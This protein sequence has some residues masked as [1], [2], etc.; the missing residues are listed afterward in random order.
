M[1][2]LE[3][4]PSR[5]VLQDESCVMS[6]AHAN[7]GW[8]VL[9]PILLGMSIP[10][11]L[12]ALLAPKLLPNGPLVFGVYLVATFVISSVIFV[13]SVF[14]P[15]NIIEATFDSRKRA[16]AFVRMGTFGTTFFSVPFSAI[17]A[18]RID[19]HTDRDEHRVAHPVVE[20]VS[21]ELLALPTGTTPAQLHEIQ[22]VIGRR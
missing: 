15:G 9:A 2:V 17:E 18:V 10:G 8:H 1:V 7:G 16:A 22:A 3:T 4:S 14:N 6:Q 19:V 13:R 20:L 12:L 11:I 5:L 21:G